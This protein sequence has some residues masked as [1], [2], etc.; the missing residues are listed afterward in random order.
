MKGQPREKSEE[1]CLYEV[2]DGKIVR[3]QFFYD[4]PAG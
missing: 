4:M 1:I 3:E 2:K